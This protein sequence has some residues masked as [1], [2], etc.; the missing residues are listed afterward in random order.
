M[1]SVHSDLR[2][3]LEKGAAQ[4][5]ALGPANLPTMFERANTF[6]RDRVVP[7]RED[8]AKA[9]TPRTTKPDQ[10]LGKVMTPNKP[11]MPGMV[12]QEMP[13]TTEATARAW[14]TE[15]LTVKGGGVTQE[16]IVRTQNLTQKYAQL[17]EDVKNQI[18]GPHKQDV[19]DLMKTLRATHHADRYAAN[20]SGSGSY[21]LRMVQAGAAL[22]APFRAIRGDLARL[23]FDAA[24]LFTPAI[25]AKIV[26]SPGGAK[27][28]T[29]GLTVPAGTKEAA[30]VAAQIVARIGAGNPSDPP[31][32][33]PDLDRF[34]QGGRQ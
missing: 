25:F 2:D 15:A 4:D 7:F 16:G 10:V 12:A 6:W 21:G 32:V 13:N 17:G 3:M 34:L 14:L 9:I 31:P 8:V 20:P 19:D 11:Y 30:T 28:L 23:G 1:Q 33:A 22:D 24:V 5:Q 26:T 27:W 29:K 18:F